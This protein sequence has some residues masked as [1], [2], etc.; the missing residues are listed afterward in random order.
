V[1]THPHGRNKVSGGIGGVFRSGW[2]WTSLVLQLAFAG[3]GADVRIIN[4]SPDFVK[5]VASPLLLLYGCC[6]R[7]RSYLYIA[8]GTFDKYIEGEASLWRWLCLLALRRSAA[9]MTQTMYLTTSLKKHGVNSVYVPN[10]T[11][12]DRKAHGPVTH[13]LAAEVRSRCRFVF[14]GDLRPEK[15]I[16]EVIDAFAAL[17]K[18]TGDARDSVS[19]DMFGPLASECKALV[20]EAARAYSNI[21]YH[22]QVSNAVIAEKLWQYTAL[23]LPTKH[24]NEG[25]PGVVLEAFASGVPVICSDHRSLVEIVLDGE[26]GLLC[27]PGNVESLFSA[28]RR[29]YD[30]SDLRMRLGAGALKSSEIFSSLTVLRQVCSI[31]NMRC[32]GP[33]GT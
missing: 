15:G 3:I 25:Y 12:L 30:D 29:F 20:E 18:H 23:L 5:Y 22:G 10:W 4:G 31:A 16:R 8:G 14:V 26:N 17:Q 2:R 9:V 32:R 28:M 6:G 21:I 24:V 11:T 33:E 13:P 7:G 27:K 19:L 1:N